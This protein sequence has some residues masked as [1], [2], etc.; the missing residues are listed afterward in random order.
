MKIWKYSGIFLMLTG[1]IHNAVAILL[2][3][4]IY[5]EIMRDGFVDAVAGDFD[6]W[7]AFWFFA[8]GIFII[9]LG[10]AVHLSIRREQRPAPASLGW[11]LLAL[12]VVIC[13]AE[14]ISGSWLFIPQALII[15]V[16]NRK[17]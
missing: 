16:A 11:T 4:D 10:Q 3:H 6:R 2:M 5:W 14:P 15:I 12:S 13:I 7:F 1:V 17:Q 8:C 9:L